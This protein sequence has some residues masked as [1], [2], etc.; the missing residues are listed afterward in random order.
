[1][2]QPIVST[3]NFFRR[4]KYLFLVIILAIV[5]LAGYLASQV[6]LEEDIFKMVLPEDDTSHYAEALSNTKLLDYLVIRVYNQDTSSHETSQLISYANEK[7]KAL[8]RSFDSTYIRK[9]QYKLGR[10]IM[11]DAFD[12]FSRNLPVFLEKEDYLYLDSI[13]TKENIRGSIENNYR[14]LISP[15]SIAMK[16]FLVQDPLGVTSRTLK[17]LE[18]FQ[19]DDGFVIQNGRIFTRDGNNLLMLVS[20]ANPS[21]ETSKNAFLVDGIGTLLDSLNRNTAFGAKGEYFGGVA[22]SVANAERIK[23]DVALTVGIAL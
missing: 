19:P 13:L 1:M 23:K 20:P 6:S 22:V 9:I 15:A 5:L 14:T 21:S 11:S 12:E 18:S 7:K 8:D 10:D 17:K 16:K 3:Y 2:I 4:G